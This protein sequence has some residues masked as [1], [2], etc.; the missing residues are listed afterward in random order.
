MV[1]EANPRGVSVGVS[2]IKRTI[3]KIDKKIV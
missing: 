1:R 3:T 2:A